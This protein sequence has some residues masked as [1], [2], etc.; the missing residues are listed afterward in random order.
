MQQ[1]RQTR[2]TGGIRLAILGIALVLA[3]TGCHEPTGIQR[4]NRRTGTQRANRRTDTQ[5]ANRRTDTQRANRRTDTQRANRRTGELAPSEPTCAP[6]SNEHT[7]ELEHL[8]LGDTF[9]EARAGVQLVLSYDA[10]TDYG[11]K[12]TFRGTVKNTTQTPLHRVIVEV[13]LY[14]PSYWT[15]EEC[16]TIPDGSRPTVLGPV[17]VVDLAP[18]QIVEITFPPVYAYATAVGGPRVAH[19]VPAVWSAHAIVN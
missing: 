2:V 5:R 1:P 6:A 16:R 8:E 3:L 14:F 11:G 19:D 4:A 12:G 15:P 10:P 9:I 13:W 17:N 7:S 18:G